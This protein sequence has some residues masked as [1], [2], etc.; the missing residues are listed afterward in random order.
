M[1]SPRDLFVEISNQPV[2][3]NGESVGYFVKNFH[4]D[5]LKEFLSVNS[6]QP[7]PVV[8][9]EMSLADAINFVE[10]VGALSE[11]DAAHQAWNACR[12]AMLSEVTC[13]K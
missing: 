7:A 10:E 12:A 11:A 3:E 2:L 1:I 6:P 4:M 8:P 9:E 5:T 13:T